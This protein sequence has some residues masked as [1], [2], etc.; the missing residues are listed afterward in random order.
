MTLHLFD[1][2]EP[3]PGPTLDEILE[4][5]WGGKD[6]SVVATP[7]LLPYQPVWTLLV[8]DHTERGPDSATVD[9]FASRERALWALWFDAIDSASDYGE[10]DSVAD[11]FVAILDKL[12][13][14]RD[15]HY[16]F[17]GDFSYIL[18]ER[19]VG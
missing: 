15:Y 10:D 8:I 18:A 9:C 4:G 12:Q 16:F 7:R 14:L 5:F 2:S 19:R 11:W 3:E 6:P 17:D 1:K 13:N